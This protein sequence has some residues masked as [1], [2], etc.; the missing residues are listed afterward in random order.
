M[1]E[2]L[3]EASTLC[4]IA[5]VS[6]TRAHVNTAYFAWTPEYHVVW[7]SDARSSHSRNLGK[8]S[9]AAIAVFDSN[10]VWGKEDRGVQL[11]GSAR[12]AGGRALERARATYSGRFPAYTAEKLGGYDV[13]DFRPR[14]VKLFA[15]PEL[16]AGSF[17]TAKVAADGALAW[18]RT[19][20]VRGS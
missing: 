15:E 3:L 14:R 20:I 6:G 19:E 2:R 1:L 17:V 12:R 5:T 9:T 7:I 18:E 13:Y 8:N 10:Q 16:G 11:F 4:A